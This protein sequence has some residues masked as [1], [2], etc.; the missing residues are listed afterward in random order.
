L[1]I[2][3]RIKGMGTEK[4]QARE[5][6]AGRP[7][8]VVEAKDLP[9]KPGPTRKEETERDH[10]SKGWGSIMIRR[11]KR[12]QEINKSFGKSL[13]RGQQ[14]GGKKKERITLKKNRGPTVKR[15][16]LGKR[17]REKDLGKDDYAIV[18]LPIG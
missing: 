6:R 4:D 11:E 13:K 1:D 3:E 7:G 14:E 12:R 10:T 15:K 8:G 9:G 17:A 2:Y 16:Y 18:H 5:K